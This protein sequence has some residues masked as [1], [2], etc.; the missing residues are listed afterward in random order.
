MGNQWRVRMASAFGMARTE[1]ILELPL[2]ATL[3]E[4]PE[5]AEE[6]LKFYIE[7]LSLTCQL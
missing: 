5:V 7:G 2:Y 6:Q 4:L 3:C 1:G